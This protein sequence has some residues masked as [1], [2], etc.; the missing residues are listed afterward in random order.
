VRPYYVVKCKAPDAMKNK[1]DMA[2][3]VSQGESP[4]PPE[5]NQCKRTV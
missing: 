3:I 2:A 1:F 5:L 4:Q